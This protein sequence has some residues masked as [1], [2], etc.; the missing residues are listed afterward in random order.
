MM[1]LVGGRTRPV[2]LIVGSAS[3][4]CSMLPLHL[5]VLDCTVFQVH[6]AFRRHVFFLFWG[7]CKETWSCVTS[8]ARSQGTVSCCLLPWGACSWNSCQEEVQADLRE[9]HM[10]RNQGASLVAP[11]EVEASTDLPNMWVSRD[12]REPSSTRIIHSKPCHA[13]RSYLH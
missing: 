7:R 10:E 8:E 1:E 5:K 9:A 4:P 11:A 3:N 13:K 2:C 6:L 12:P